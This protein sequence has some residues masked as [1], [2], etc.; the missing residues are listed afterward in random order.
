MKR[1]GVLIS[2]AVLLAC[3][4]HALAVRCLGYPV[5]RIVWCDDFDT[6]CTKNCNNCTM[7]LQEPY[8]VW[9]GY[10]PDPDNWCSTSDTVSEWYFRRS[11][12]WPNLCQGPGLDAMAPVTTSGSAYNAPYSVE[13]QGGSNSAQRH[14]HDM[15]SEITTRHPGYEAVNGT[16]AHPLVLMYW[17]WSSVIGGYP[18]SPMYVEL[19]KVDNP[20]APAQ[21]DERAPTDYIWANCGSK[22]YPIVC[23]QRVQ[24]TRWECPPLSTQ[25]HASLCFG[26]LAQL[27]RN[28]CDLDTGTKPTMYNAATFDGLKW[29][30][31]VPTLFP[32]YGEFK[33]DNGG[34][35][36]TMTIKTSSYVVKLES[37]THGTSE[38]TI[39]RQ[40]TG[41]FNKVGIGTGLS[42]QL[43]PD[44]GQCVGSYSCWNYAQG[45]SDWGWN[46]VNLDTPVLLDGVYQS[47]YGACCHVDGVCEEV[48]EPSCRG[49]HDRFAG[50]NTTCQDSGYKCCQ[51]PFADADHDGDVDQVDFSYL[52]LCYTGWNGGVASGCECFNRDS[53]NDVDADDMADFDACWTGPN[54]KYDDVVPPPTGCVP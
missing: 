2:T 14:E 17:A 10:P 18:N 9:P 48:P 38:A 13:Y 45:N 11:F 50:I 23:Q 16:N 21:P 35:W 15:T 32:G 49:V 47:L 46:K 6:Y 44:N 4:G 12:H 40:Y 42:C 27:D 26:W 52:Q 34:A 28:P 20:S 43:D 3:S 36:F 51:Y 29:H 24:P 7:P 8:S 39:P 33:H 25:V 19:M 31:L 5:T 53:D 37:V 1:R 54:V 22:S 41:P 30:D